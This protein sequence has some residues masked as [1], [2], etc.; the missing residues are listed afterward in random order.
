MKFNL[1][2][3]LVRTF[4]IILVPSV[5]LLRRG[6]TGEVRYILDRDLRKNYWSWG[7]FVVTSLL[8]WKALINL[9]ATEFLEELGPVMVGLFFVLLNLL[10]KF[11]LRTGGLVDGS[12]V[13][14]W[15]AIDSYEWKSKGR[16]YELVL[17]LNKGLF[18]RK[19]RFLIAA[20]QKD[21]V[22]RV[23]SSTLSK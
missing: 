23:L 15:D 12:T 2:T 10:S 21:L 3:L 9:T 1:A 18:L 4:V 22:D 6:R 17:H 5:V 8:V 16:R 11:E 20:A 19:A 13:V 14:R 7:I